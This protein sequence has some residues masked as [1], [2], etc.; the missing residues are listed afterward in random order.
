MFLSTLYLLALAVCSLSH[1]LSQLLTG[2]TVWPRGQ[3]LTG[4][5]LRVVLGSSTQLCTVLGSQVLKQQKPSICPSSSTFE[6]LS[7]SPCTK[8]Y[9]TSAMGDLSQWPGM[10]S[11]VSSNKQGPSANFTHHAQGQGIR[12]RCLC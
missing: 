1:C 4:Q 2:V 10:S 7:E 11:L 3:T 5:A 6:E 8:S 9:M 12:F